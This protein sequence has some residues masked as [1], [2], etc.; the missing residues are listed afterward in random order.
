MKPSR[1]D[2]SSPVAALW[3]LPDASSASPG[4]PPVSAYGTVLPLLRGSMPALGPPHRGL[5]GSET[6]T[7]LACR[8]WGQ[9]SLILARIQ[10]KYM[11]PSAHGREDK[12]IYQRHRSQLGGCRLT[13]GA[14]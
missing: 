14:S 2:W 9:C 5:A 8:R 6:T 12:V 10:N 11:P 3:G 7:A 4:L 1:M 13:T